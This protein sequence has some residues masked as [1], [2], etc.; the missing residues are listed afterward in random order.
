MLKLLE[1]NDSLVLSCLGI[2]EPQLNHPLIQTIKPLWQRVPT[3]DP[4]G[5]PYAD[6]MMLIPKL[7]SFE[8]THI[9]DII[10]KV[11]AVLKK[12]ENDIV[13][14]DLNLKINTLWVTVKPRIGLTSE[15]AALI[16]HVIPEAKLVSQH[17]V[18]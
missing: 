17:K 7:K 8:P 2:N 16:H 15:I 14:A 4:A 12:Y 6:F 10:C 1:E 3:R 9:R 11:E 5:Q 18:S 13:L